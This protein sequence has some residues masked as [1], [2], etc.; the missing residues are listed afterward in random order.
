MPGTKNIVILGASVGGLGI[1]HYIVR[2]TLPKLQ[3]VQDVKY[4]LHLVDPSTHFWWH[5]AAPRE[6]VSVKAMEHSKCFV[7]IMDGFQQYASLKD[8]VVFHHG[9]ATDLDTKARKVSIKTHEGDQEFLDYYAL[10]IATGVRSPTPLTT[11]H[12]DHTISQKALEEANEQLASAKDIVI[13]GGGPVG[14]ETAGEIGYT[15]GGKAKITLIAGSDKLLPVLRKGLADKAQKL[16]VKNGVTVRYSI[17]VTAAE[18]QADGRTEIQ[19][20]NGEK[21]SADVYIPA[22][23][24]KPN[25]EW[26]PENLK[27]KTGYVATNPTTLRVDGA[28]PRVYAA[29]DVAA[30]D[31]GGVLL[32]FSSTPVLGANLTHD[33]LTDAK[34]GGALAEKAYKRKDA[35]TQLVPVG[36]KAGVAAFNGFQMPGFIVPIVKGRDYMVSHMPNITQGKKYAKA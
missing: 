18:K 22:A 4:V 31:N 36:P 19:L 25:T 34:V 17:K 35:E 26:L 2:H 23:G 15:Y 1:A 11:L 30:V 21:M 6:I 24:V 9:S 12:G 7:P 8:S 27:S 14:V 20:D 3:Q 28:G 33:L 13:S 5:V 32:S 29:G 10:V 16:L